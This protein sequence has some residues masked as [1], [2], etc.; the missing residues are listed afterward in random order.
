MKP[1]HPKTGYPFWTATF[2][3]QR[4]ALVTA[5]LVTNL[6]RL[7]YV[8]GE[9]GAF[10]LLSPQDAR[11]RQ[12]ALTN[13]LH[14]LRG[15]EVEARLHGLLRHHHPPVCHTVQHPAA[16]NRGVKK[17]K[18]SQKNDGFDMLRTRAQVGLHHAGKTSSLS[19]PVKSVGSC[20][21]L[22]PEACSMI[23]AGTGDGSGNT[24]STS[25]CKGKKQ[26]TVQLML[27]IPS[28]SLTGHRAKAVG[29]DGQ[30]DPPPDRPRAATVWKGYRAQVR[31]AGVRHHHPLKVVRVRCGTYSLF[32]S[33]IGAR[34][35]Y[36]LSPSVI[37]A[38]SGY[39]FAAPR[40]PRFPRQASAPRPQSPHC[41]SKDPS[42]P[43]PGGPSTAR[44]ASAA[45]APPNPPYPHDTDDVSAQWPPCWDCQFYYT[46]ET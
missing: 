16:R 33:A 17:D 27:F 2:L 30:T 11:G 12:L 4:K 6:L 43:P 22:T 14:A 25:T 21:V 5:R 15:H 45:P 39:I 40:P 34:Y 19:L 18:G 31:P 24:G 36:I 23:M 38:R 29:R 42:L 44:K 7:L 20:R 32:P 35:G 37:G 10:H 28:V 13:G 3:K 8:A 1:S 9:R 46:H 41:P 26:D